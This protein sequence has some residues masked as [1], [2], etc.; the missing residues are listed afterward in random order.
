[1]QQLKA[2]KKYGQNFLKNKEILENIANLVKVNDNDLIIEIGPGMGALTEYLTKKDSY[3]WGYEID[4]RMQDYLK[5]LEN[6][7]TH[8]I[9]DDFMKHDLQKDLDLTKYDN[10]YVIANIPYYITSPIILKLIQSGVNFKNIVLLV[11]KEFAERLTA[12]AGSKEYNA[13]TIYV[14]YFYKAKLMFLVNKNNFSPV[15]KVDSAVIMLEKNKES[16]VINEEGYFEF[17]KDAF[18]NKRKTLKNNMYNYDWNKILNGLK[19]MNYTEN[20]RA[21]EINKEDFKKLWNYYNN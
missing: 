2:I 15:P 19:E 5:K 3:L 13:F 7:K 18:K 16:K 14:D 21:E 17:I 8:F 11:Q 6:E 1:M 20:V 10:I 9:Y 12:E 4:S